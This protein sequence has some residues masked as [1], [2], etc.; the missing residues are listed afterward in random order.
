MVEQEETKWL[1]RLIL[2]FD[3]LRE[4]HDKEGL[5]SMSIQS[6][7]KASA[8]LAEVFENLGFALKFA[9]MDILDK[10]NQ[11]TKPAVLDQFSTFGALLQADVK[12]NSVATKGSLARMAHNLKRAVDF[13]H[14]LLEQ[15]IT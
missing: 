4:E 1:L 10:I 6:F 14:T 13:V 12:E 3:K 7:A 11:L 9:A 5:N 2:A 8:L 15:I